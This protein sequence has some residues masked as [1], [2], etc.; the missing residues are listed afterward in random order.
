MKKALMT[1]GILA[2]AAGCGGGGGSSSGGG[3]SAYTSEPREVSF[4]VEPS[5]VTC[6]N[7]NDD[8]TAKYSAGS[9][10]VN[11]KSCYWHCGS[12]N[13]QQGRYIA[14]TWQSQNGGPWTKIIDLNMEGLCR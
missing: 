3:S 11:Q 8:S 12:Y 13:G 1:L 5:G 6:F 14:F 9:I 2:L 10:T 7:Q 4:K